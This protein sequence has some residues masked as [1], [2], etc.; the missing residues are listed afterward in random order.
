MTEPAI[1]CRDL[2]KVY[3]IGERQSY[4]TLRESLTNA[5]AAPF[6]MFSPRGRDDS[7]EPSEF[8]ALRG[9]SFDVAHGEIL[10]IIGHNGAGKSTLL[11]VLSRITAPTEGQVEIAGRVG[12]LLEVGTGFHP[13]L[14]GRENI[15]LNGSILG[16]RRKDITRK[17]DDIVAFAEVE[18]FIDTPVKRFSSGM[19]V[20]LAFAVAVHLE[21]EIL[22]ID[23][24]L[25][26]GDAEF[27]K[28]CLNKIQEIGK[29]NRTILLVSHNMAAIRNICDRAMLLERGRIVEIGDAN[30]TIDGYLSRIRVPATGDVVVE[31]PSFRVDDLEIS[32]P[33]GSV[34]KTFEPFEIALTVTA[35]ADLAEPDVY[36]GILTMDGTL[37]SALVCRDFVSIPPLRAGKTITITF[38]VESLPLLPGEYQLELRLVDVI[39]YKFE[40]APRT[41][42]FTIAETPIYGSRKIDRWYGNVGLKASVSVSAQTT[43]AT[44]AAGR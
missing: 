16:M 42:G 17:F 26:V 43:V 39:G 14:T 15:Y 13:E 21:P 37:V 18:R 2:G 35:K 8:W 22:I 29:G 20:R 12:S 24:V 30:R 11:K 32:G 25:A 10:G 1:Q 44:G 23:E 6:R 34:I 3:T 31:T 33:S 28:K 4:K 38:S 40:I 7:A 27:Q 36:A 41:F 5:F 9:V 19:Y